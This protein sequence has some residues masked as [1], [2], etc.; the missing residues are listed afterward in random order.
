MVDQPHVLLLGDSVIMDGV[1]ESLLK[2]KF[3]NVTRINS[4]SQE[5]REI[6]ISLTPDL[7][8]Y[9]L[10]AKN[11]DPIFTI[12]REQPDTLH[13]AIDLN[14][15]QVILLDCQRKPTASMQELCELIS[16]EVSLKNIEKEV[17]AAQIK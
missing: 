4:N 8:V 5:A 16:Q 11:T 15:N 3:S 7:I 9:E 12:I 2:R 13:L 6:V 10:N 17:R 14:C 1:A